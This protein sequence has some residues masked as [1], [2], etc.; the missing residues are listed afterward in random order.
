MTVMCLF[1]IFIIS[2]LIS[3]STDKF[4]NNTLD[5]LLINRFVTGNITHTPPLS[6]TVNLRRFFLTFAF[7]N[8]TFSPDHGF[9]RHRSAI[10]AHSF[11]I[12]N[13]FKLF[14]RILIFLLLALCIILAR[15]S[16]SYFSP[17]RVFCR[18]HSAII[19]QAL[20]R[21]QTAI[22][23]KIS[24]FLSCFHHF[25]RGN[26]THPPR[27]RIFSNSFP[28]F[29]D[30][31]WPPLG[32]QM[33]TH[34][35]HRTSILLPQP[36]SVQSLHSTAPNHRGSRSQPRLVIVSQPHFRVSKYQVG[37]Q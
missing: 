2:A 11:Q 21:P 25:H 32:K 23:R 5:Y 20:G 17:D 13:E 34:V 1:S 26:L 33:A 4:N 22:R 30:S 19:A 9:C 6:E 29:S 7:V 37:G 24:P 8:R 14:L 15:L 16:S 28:I 27:T 12:N 36:N 18:R 31:T 10:I 35:A 3:N